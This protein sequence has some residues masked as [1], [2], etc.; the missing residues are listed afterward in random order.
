MEKKRKGVSR[1]YLYQCR[2]FR[3]DLMAVKGPIVRKKPKTY[4]KTCLKS[5]VCLYLCVLSITHVRSTEPL[6]FQGQ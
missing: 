4:N 6:G 3:P 2:N 5:L 1:M